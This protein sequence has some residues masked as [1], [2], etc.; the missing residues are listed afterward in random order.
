MHGF[1]GWRRLIIVALVAN[2]ACAWLGRDESVDP[3]LTF[4]AHSDSGGLVIDKMEGGQQG[5]LVRS[6]IGPFQRGPQLLL[7]TATG[8]AAALWVEDPSIVVR[9]AG[10][11][12]APPVGRVDT[13]WDGGAIQLAL[14]AEGDGTYRTSAFARTDG[15]AVPPALGQPA[16]LTVEIRGEYVAVVWDEQGTQAGWLRVRTGVDWGSMSRYEGVLPAPVNGP[17]AVAAVARLEREINAM[18]YQAVDP[19]IGN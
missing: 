17:V 10:D 8:P 2:A 7:E 14:I 9:Q 16:N 3:N 18:R 4:A 15:G 19:H 12:S 1:N 5:R 6:A 13:T 11:P